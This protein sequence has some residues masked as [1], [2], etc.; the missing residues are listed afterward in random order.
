MCL[1]RSNCSF[2]LVVDFLAMCAEIASLGPNCKSVP[3]IANL[4]P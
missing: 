4:F 2:M 1:N 3:L